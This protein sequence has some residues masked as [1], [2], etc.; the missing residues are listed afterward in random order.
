V[1][2]SY[3]LGDAF[4][5]AVVREVHGAFN[6]ATHPVLDAKEVSRILGARPVPVSRR[7]ARAAAGL[8]WR[9]H[10]QPVPPGWL[11]LALNVPVM[12]TRRAREELGW[13]PRYTAG[14]TLINVL[15]GL[16]D[17]AGLDTPVLSPKT[18]GAFRVREF[19]TGIGSREP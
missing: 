3:D 12:D 1:V 17:G 2:H 6:V 19:L 4:L 15:E 8:S 7:I 10:L 13:S 9:L 11:D 16:R 18:G 5:R 14:G